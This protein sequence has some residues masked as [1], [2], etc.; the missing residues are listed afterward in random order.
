MAVKK[1]SPQFPFIPLRKAIDR[2][3]M[4]Y[5]KEKTNETNIATAIDNIGYSP[6]ASGGIQSI[7]AL[8]AYGLIDSRGAGD[9]RAVRVTGLARR[10]LLD[11]RTESPDRENL[12]K[13]AAL[14]PGIFKEIWALY[15]AHGLP[16]DDNIRHYL[17]FERGFN[18]GT[19][20]NFIKVLKD[21]ISFASLTPSD[22]VGEVGNENEE[23][24]MGSQQLAESVKPEPEFIAHQAKV[25]VTPSTSGMTEIG[26]IRV[27]RG[28]A[29]RLI[30]DGPYSKK[31]IEALVAQ[32]NLGLELGTYD[33]PDEKEVSFF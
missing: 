25:S 32:L 21:N 24:D 4:L 30:A 1:R 6:K 3:E 11:T 10:I 5:K 20:S 19:V 9:K 8:I 17:I 18:E 12:L 13:Q 16:S 26:N 33:D 28:C 29:I 22:I 23:I 31:S 7:A 15:A 2:A 27:S 14:A